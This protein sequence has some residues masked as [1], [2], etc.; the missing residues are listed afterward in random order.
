MDQ[1]LNQRLADLEK[2]VDEIWRSAEQIR[3][4]FLW[5][6]IIGVGMVILPLIGLAFAIPSF[7]KTF[8]TSGLGL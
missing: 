3:K 7:L 1:D 2:K 4:I 6:L 8:D 5:T